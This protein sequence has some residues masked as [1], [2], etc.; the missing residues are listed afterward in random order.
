M[1]A[2][3]FAGEKLIEFS[4]LKAIYKGIE[5]A[6]DTISW[7]KNNE[8]S[9]YKDVKHVNK[10]LNKYDIEVKLN[11]I[12]SLCKEI[13][14]KSIHHISSI[15]HCIEQIEKSIN[16]IEFCLECVKTKIYKHENSWFSYWRMIQFGSEIED[17]QTKCIIFENRVD[18]LVKVFNI[19]LNTLKIHN[20]FTE[21]QKNCSLEG[22]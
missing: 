8:T 7:F 16:D 12:G 9:F 17:L 21:Q 15:K 14:K 22:K 18:I 3:W 11:V 6:S 19:H 13:E 10:I 1:Y 2:L 4:G 5:Y 20:D